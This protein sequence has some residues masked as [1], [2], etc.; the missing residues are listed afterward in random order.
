MPNDAE[1]PVALVTG[2]RTGV[3]RH[4]AQMLLERGYAVIGCSRK[5]LDWEPASEQYVHFDT[6]VTSEEQVKKLF[7][8]ITRRFG[9]LDVVINNAGVASMNHVLLTPVSSL[10][11]MLD[12]HVCGTHAISREAA[13]LMRKHK[14]GR[15][16]NFSSVATPLN[17]EGQAAYVASK[18]SVEALS[19]VMAKELREF[20]ITVNVIGPGPT[21]TD[22][23]R[24][25]PKAKLE[26]MVSVFPVKRLT[27]MEEIVS[28]IDLLL[29]PASSAISGQVIYLAGVPNS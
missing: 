24:G 7:G 22:M 23:I 29:L 9:R 2:T 27:T 12:T 18:A 14:Y 4:L 15:I 8:E 10:R 11:R 28:A 3:G 1:T 25:V 21:P 20:G 5:P 17:Y 16:I 13:L 6:D 19:R 26:K